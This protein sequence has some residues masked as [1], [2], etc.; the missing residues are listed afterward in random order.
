VERRSTGRRSERSCSWRSAT[1]LAKETTA[2][3]D[4]DDDPQRLAWLRKT[5]ELGR[6]DLD[7]AVELADEVGVQVDMATVARRRYGASMNYPV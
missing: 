2:P 7:D 5:V 1:Q 6:K 4:P 3:I